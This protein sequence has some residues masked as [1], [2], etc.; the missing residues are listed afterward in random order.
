MADDSGSSAV[1]GVIVGAILVIAV[2]F[3][4]F[5]GFDIFRGDGEIDVDIQ[6]PEVPA[7]GGP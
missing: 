6:V 4:A 5:G 7:G 2:L 3:F 1:L